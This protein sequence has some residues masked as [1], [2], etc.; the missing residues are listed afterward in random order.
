MHQFQAVMPHYTAME[1]CVHLSKLQKKSKEQYT[2]QAS[3]VIN[4]EEESLNVD[5]ETGEYT[6]PGSGQRK[7]ANGRVDPKDALR[8]EA[9]Y[10]ELLS[11]FYDAWKGDYGDEVATQVTANVKDVCD[12]QRLKYR[13][14]NGACIRVHWKAC[15]HIRMVYIRHK[16][17]FTFADLWKLFLSRLKPRCV[18]KFLRRNTKYWTRLMAAEVTFSDF[19]DYLLEHSEISVDNRNDSDI[20]A[21]YDDTE[22]EKGYITDENDKL[23]PIK[24]STQKPQGGHKGHTAGHIPHWKPKANVQPAEAGILDLIYH[25]NL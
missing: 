8:S 5:I 10:Q 15:K 17:P 16:V 19:G 3:T 18:R 20:N 21:A 2:T 4:D 9:Y 7:L 12:R 6:G 14:E 25:P 22:Q 13:M 23:V 24:K 11:R 1:A